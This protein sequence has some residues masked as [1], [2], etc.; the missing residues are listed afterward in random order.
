MGCRGSLV[1]VQSPRPS[2]KLKPATKPR[3]PSE[4]MVFFLWI[5]TLKRPSR[6]PA[7]QLQVIRPPDACP[8]D[9]YQERRQAFT[10]NSRYPGRWEEMVSTTIDLATVMKHFEV[11]NRTDGKSERTVG[12]YNEVLG[13]LLRSLEGRTDRRPLKPSTRWS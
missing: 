6:P 1:R 12:W 8:A 2:F 7:L 11:H 13:L 5:S 10:M 4:G 3:R 9:A